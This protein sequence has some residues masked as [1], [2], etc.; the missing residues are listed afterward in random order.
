M[1][2]HLTTFNEDCVALATERS[3]FFPC[4]FRTAAAGVPEVSGNHHHLVKRHAETRW[5]G[6]RRSSDKK[7]LV[8]L[9]Q[10]SGVGHGHEIGRGA[11][12]TAV[13]HE[14]DLSDPD[15]ELISIIS[16]E[17]ADERRPVSHALENLE[18]A[19]VVANSRAVSSFDPSS[20]SNNV[21]ITAGPFDVGLRGPREA[22]LHFRRRW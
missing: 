5:D 9:S 19:A 7:L 8:P 20:R 11:I 2:V 15:N 6:R 21:T 4:Y 16:Q 14:A 18:E 13:L 3:D 12:A 17:L 22:N 1:F 10:S